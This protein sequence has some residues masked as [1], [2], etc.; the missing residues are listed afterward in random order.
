M[1][2]PSE[3]GIRTNKTENIK[4]ITLTMKNH[5]TVSSN[6]TITVFFVWTHKIFYTKQESTVT[7]IFTQQGAFWPYDRFSKRSNSIAPIKNEITYVTSKSLVCASWVFKL[8]S[9][10]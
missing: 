8:F 6:M 10:Y 1:T 3:E 7:D 5:R 4:A 2:L 9:K